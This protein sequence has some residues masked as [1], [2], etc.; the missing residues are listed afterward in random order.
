MSTTA[1]NE[2]LNDLIEINNDRIK[3]YERAI[4][5]VQAADVD[6]KA[7]FAAII[8]QTSIFNQELG[9]HVAGSGDKPAESGSVLG[10]LH[11]A[12]IDVKATFTG[13]D[14]KSIL[15]ECERG[16]DASKKTYK[17]ALSE[18]YTLTPQERDLVTKQAAAQKESHDKIK[19][20]RDAEK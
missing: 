10:A 7:V 15:E 6:L 16:E 4:K 17:D 1:A 8:E 9:E 11:R 5:D 20:M 12:W 18:A 3:G 2:V 14:R 19:A 13:D